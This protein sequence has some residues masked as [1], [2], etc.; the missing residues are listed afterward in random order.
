MK[1][2]QEGHPDPGMAYMPAIG[3]KAT[4]HL[5]DGRKLVGQ[6][7]G[8][9]GHSGKRSTD[10]HFGLGAL[11]ARQ[12]L[13]VDLSWRDRQGKVQTKTIALKPGSFTIQLLAAEERETHS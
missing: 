9:S 12:D 3:A 7:D 4:V 10:L 1:L 6:I 13:T 8:G 11:R 2:V 5:P